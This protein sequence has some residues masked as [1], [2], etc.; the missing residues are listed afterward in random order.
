MKIKKPTTFYLS[1]ED[2]QALIEKA[3]LRRLSLGAFIRTTMLK[4]VEALPIKA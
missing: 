4:E 3:K 1:E 2:R